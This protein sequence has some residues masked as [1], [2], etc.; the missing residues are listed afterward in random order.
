MK[1]VFNK[2]VRDKIP[3]VIKD[4]G[5][6]PAVKKLSV[7]EYKKALLEKLI[8]EAQEIK[9]SK[10]KDEL[11]NELADIQEVLTAIYEVNKI[12]CSDVTKNARKKR[13]KRGAFKKRILLKSMIKNK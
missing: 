6:T 5:Y 13:E 8:E 9:K 4:D 11:I 10:N 2:L 3:E 12:H 1:K 7:A